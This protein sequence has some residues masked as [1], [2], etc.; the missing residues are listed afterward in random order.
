MRRI[1]R[2]LVVLGGLGLI[3]S[4]GLDATP[5]QA[6]TPSNSTYTYKLPRQSVLSRFAPRGGIGT[7]PFLGNTR[8]LGAY[9]YNYDK[10][11]PDVK[12]SFR[13]YNRRFFRR[14]R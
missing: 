3:A 5:V 1:K 12:S 2:A 7:T 9:S 8:G 6:Q 4:T 11:A 10:V 14:T 13:S